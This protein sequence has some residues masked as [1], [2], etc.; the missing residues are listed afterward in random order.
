MKHRRSPPPKQCTN[1][2]QPPAL[3]ELSEDDFTPRIITIKPKKKGFQTTIE[4]FGQS[5]DKKVTT[6]ANPSTFIDAI[7]EL[8]RQFSRLGN[9]DL[10]SPRD[11]YYMPKNTVD[12]ATHMLASQWNK[13]FFDFIAGLNCQYRIRALY[14]LPPGWVK[15][16]PNL[17]V[18]NGINAQ[19][20]AG[21]QLTQS[22]FYQFTP[23]HF[24]GTLCSTHGNELWQIAGNSQSQGNAVPF[25]PHT[26]PASGG[27]TQFGAAADSYHSQADHP[28]VSA[29]SVVYGIHQQQA[30]STPSS[31]GTDSAFSLSEQSDSDVSGLSTAYHEEVRYQP[32]VSFPPP[33][34]EGSEPSLEDLMIEEGSY[35]NLMSTGSISEDSSDSTANSEPWSLHQFQGYQHSQ[36]SMSHSAPTGPYQYRPYIQAHR[37][38]IANRGLY[39][40]PRSQNLVQQGGYTLINPTGRLAATSYV[41]IRTQSGRSPTDQHRPEVTGG[42]DIP[43]AASSHSSVTVKKVN[44]SVNEEVISATS[45]AVTEEERGAINLNSAVERYRAASDGGSFY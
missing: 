29:L 26:L 45:D 5:I 12:E 37:Q 2:K 3:H 6:D 25:S 39:D 41:R 27:D 23:D 32:P 9:V 40:T 17:F 7:L 36:A 15:G 24:Q 8:E 22:L 16:D 14:S 10:D 21:D 42:Q 31:V 35:Q 30:A 19:T 33:S 34:A 4:G 11:D 28:E 1:S 38:A 18:F 13:E 43:E 44:V 20:F